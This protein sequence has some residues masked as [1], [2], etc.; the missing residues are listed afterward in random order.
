MPTVVMTHGA[1]CGGWAF[2]AFRAP[3]EARGWTVLAPDLPR[4]GE[5]D[6]LR[7]EHSPA[8]FAGWLRDLLDALNIPAATVVGHSFG[9]GLA[10]Q[11]AYQH[12]DYCRRLVLVNSGGLGPEVTPL[13]RILS[14]PGAGL[15]LTILASRHATGGA[16]DAG[17]EVS[18][19][20]TV[21]HSLANTRNR[22]AILATLRC[23]VDRRG[24]KICALDRLGVLADLPVQIISG[25]DDK[26]IP[27]A[28]AY[29]AHHR[30]PSSRLDVI[31]GVGHSPQVQSPAAVVE[32]VDE[33][34]SQTSEHRHLATVGMRESG[35]V[36]A[37]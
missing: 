16:N 23:V 17:H 10:M 27:V 4:H 5:S 30:L 7:G 11:F 9:G 1:F 34:V 19:A 31:P 15:L 3:F 21:R 24:Q 18:E 37:A 22:Q 20:A 29:A 13:L 26:V 32:L 2:E 28:H 36:P 35:L 33:F 6:R 14:M 8:A 12:R 25:A